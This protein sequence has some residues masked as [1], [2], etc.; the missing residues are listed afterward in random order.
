MDS[1]FCGIADAPKIQKFLDAGSGGGETGV[2]GGQDGV[3][4]EPTTQLA[5]GKS[6]KRAF[7]PDVPGIHAL[8]MQL[9][10]KEDVDGRVKP[11]HD[12]L[13]NLRSTPAA[14]SA[15]PAPSATPAA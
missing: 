11:G 6:A 2:E 1:Y 8:E 13:R 15:P 4:R 5:P 3:R 9:R 7:A 14:R 10:R 12:E